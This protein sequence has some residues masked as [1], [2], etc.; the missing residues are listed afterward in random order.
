M[1]EKEIESLIKWW[2]NTDTQGMD[3]DKHLINPLMEAFGDDA[4]EIIAYLDDM[5]VEDLDLI[6]GCFEAIYGKFTTDEVYEVLGELEDK[7][8]N[9]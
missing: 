1:D 8:N 3:I 7:L 9:A 2:K 6:S 4:D 5:D